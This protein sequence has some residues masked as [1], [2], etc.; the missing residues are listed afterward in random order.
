MN[1]KHVDIWHLRGNWETDN[2]WT[3]V[4]GWSPPAAEQASRF[5][6]QLVLFSLSAFPNGAWVARCQSLSRVWLFVILWPVAHRALLSMEFFRQ[7]YGS[8]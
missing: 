2:S 6:R 8:G 5:L 4:S 1:N 7:E 3:S